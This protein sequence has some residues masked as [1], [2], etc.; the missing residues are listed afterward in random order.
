M[1]PRHCP[2]DIHRKA[3]L[4]CLNKLRGWEARGFQEHLE[5]CEECRTIV[6]RKQAA[7]SVARAACGEFGRGFLMPLGA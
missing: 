6:G 4:Y 1:S 7:V 2:E 3:A 5:Q